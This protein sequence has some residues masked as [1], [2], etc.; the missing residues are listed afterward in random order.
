MHVMKCE[1]VYV[2]MSICICF[3]YTQKCM[4]MVHVYMLYVCMRVCV[5]VCM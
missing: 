1:H 2:C 4:H 5:Y 3:P